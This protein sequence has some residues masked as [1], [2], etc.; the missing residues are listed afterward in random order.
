[1]RATVMYGAG[2]VRAENVPD[3]VGRDVRIVK[4][5]DLVVTPFAWPDGTCD[6]G[7]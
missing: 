6:G 1:M 4:R 5:G 2:D 3:A 7:G